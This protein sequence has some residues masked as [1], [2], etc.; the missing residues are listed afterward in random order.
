MLKFGMKTAREEKRRDGRE[1]RG[2]Q[3]ERET[4]RW[5]FTPVVGAD[6]R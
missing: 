3:I 2:Q 6:R 4:D 1:G 5:R